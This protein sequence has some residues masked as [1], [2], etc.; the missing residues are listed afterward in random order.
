MVVFDGFINDF[1]FF[2]N[3][4][5]LNVLTKLKKK[6]KLTLI[7]STSTVQISWLNVNPCEILL[8]HC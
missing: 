4:H 2:N 3:F 5:V 1:K 7:Y 6:K 8:C